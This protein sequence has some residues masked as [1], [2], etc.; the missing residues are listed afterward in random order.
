MTYEPELQF[1]DV[2]PHARIRGCLLGGAVGDAFGAPVEFYGVTL[3]ASTAR[4]T[5]LR[6][7]A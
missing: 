6:A 2:T 4:T 3:V 1:G 7:F 5:T